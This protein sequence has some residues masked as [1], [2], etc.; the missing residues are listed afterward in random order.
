MKESEVK[1]EILSKLKINIEDS[2][3]YMP[4]E[5]IKGTIELNPSLKMKIKNNILHFKLKILSVNFRNI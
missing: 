3:F 2:L 5:T 1:E 4:G